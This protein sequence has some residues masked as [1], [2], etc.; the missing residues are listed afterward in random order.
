MKKNLIW[1]AL[2]AYGLWYVLRKKKVGFLKSQ[3]TAAGK[4]AKRM[5]ANVVDQTT[6]E[7]DNTT[8]ADLYAQ[9]K[10]KCL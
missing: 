5:V 7:P 4:T 1:Y 8:F 9:D 10:A 3:E 2:A 6:F